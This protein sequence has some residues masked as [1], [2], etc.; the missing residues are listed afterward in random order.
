M[1][2]QN[3]PRNIDRLMPKVNE[4]AIALYSFIAAYFAQHEYMPTVREMCKFAGGRSTSIISYHL[5]VLV[6][7][8]WIERPVNT[9]RGIR[10]MRSTER[11]LKPGQLRALLGLELVTPEPVAVREQ[12]G[13]RRK[14]RRLE[15]VMQLKAA[16]G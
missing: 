1:K 10:L 6:G 16:G 12:V 3:Y 14:R 8:R 15:K 13:I 2:R 5:S 11:G 4:Q 7:W 9:D